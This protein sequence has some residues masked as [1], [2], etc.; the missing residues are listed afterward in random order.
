MAVRLSALRA[1]HTLPTKNVLVLI[2]GKVR[3]NLRA[4]M[5]LERLSKNEKKKKCSDLIGTRTRKP[6]GL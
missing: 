2:S 6:F 1:G 4:M 5:R 3:V